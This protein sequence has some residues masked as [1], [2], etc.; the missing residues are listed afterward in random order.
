MLTPKTMNLEPARGW[1][2]L[3]FKKAML[4]T[5]CL[6]AL[7]F[8]VLVY[9]IWIQYFSRH[10]APLMCSTE[11]YLPL[12]QDQHQYHSAVSD[13]DEKTERGDSFTP[14]VWIEDSGIIMVCVHITRNCVRGLYFVHAR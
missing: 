8:G 3:F 1:N 6:G 12:S 5:R 4:W 11:T 10:Q 13:D 2:N 7:Q 9:V 14:S